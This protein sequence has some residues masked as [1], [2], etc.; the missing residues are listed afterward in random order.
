MGGRAD[1]YVD[2]YNLAWHAVMNQMDIT[3]GSNKYYKMQLLRGRQQT[4]QYYVFKAWGR[5]GSGEDSR[6][7]GDLVHHATRQLR[8]GDL[9]ELRSADASAASA[10]SLRSTSGAWKSE[11]P[12]GCSFSSRAARSASDDARH[13]HIFAPVT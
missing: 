8:S 4:P 2:E 6:V 11:V 3:S 13:R 5:L 10:S 9:L 12:I 1:V 7:N